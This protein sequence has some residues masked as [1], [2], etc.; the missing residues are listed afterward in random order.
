MSDLTYQDVLTLLGLIDAGPFGTFELEFN[1]TR[2]KVVREVGREQGSS[3]T[4]GTVQTSDVKA[5]PAKDASP[6]ISAPTPVSGQVPSPVAAQEFPGAIEVK[7]PM[8][9][10]FYAAPSP[11]APAFVQ[12]GQSVKKGDQVGT[13]EVMKLFTPVLAPCDGVVRAVLARNEQLVDKEEPIMLIEPADRT[14]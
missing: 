4:A 13:V 9:G 7:P 2:L 5:S 3:R 10:T 8:G 11:G 6:G 14:S 12:Q 1:G